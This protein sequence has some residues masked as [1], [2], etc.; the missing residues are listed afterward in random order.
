MS[1][2]VKTARDAFN[3]GKTR[4]IGFR[5]RQLDGFMKMIEECSDD[6]LACLNKEMRKSKLEGQCFFNLFSVK[7]VFV[8]SPWMDEQFFTF[9][10]IGSLY[11][12]E[13]LKTEIIKLRNCVAEFA[14]DD[15]L[16]I[17][18]LASLDSAYIK[19]QPYGVVLV[20]GNFL[21]YFIDA[22]VWYMND[23]KAKMLLL[24]TGAWNYPF[25]LSL[26]P[27]VGMKQFTILTS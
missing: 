5:K 4:D 23:A 20:L 15:K 17:N 22:A 16:P 2:V 24:F 13:V 1:Q 14:K 21:H 7:R 6:I 18:L 11:E 19:K 12:L 3:S 25:L 10:H 8:I 26:Q 27:V 9:F